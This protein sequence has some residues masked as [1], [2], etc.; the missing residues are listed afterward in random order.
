MEDLKQHVRDVYSR[1][2]TK[3]DNRESYYKSDNYIPPK[4][5][6]PVIY[7]GKEYKSKAQCCYC[8][9]ISIS[10]LNKYLNEK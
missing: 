4:N 9:N 5:S 3:F 8:E 2:Q 1:E 7:N 6:I 10:T